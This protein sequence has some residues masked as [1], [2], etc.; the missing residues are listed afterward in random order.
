F[1]GSIGRYDLPLADGPT[2]L[3]SIREE[4][5]TLPDDYTVH[6]GHGPSTTIGY[7]REFNPFIGNDAHSLS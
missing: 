2:L 3:K 7:E 5:L 6:P 4:L 1:Q